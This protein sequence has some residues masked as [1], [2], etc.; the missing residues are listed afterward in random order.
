[1]KFRPVYFYFMVFFILFQC[2]SVRYKFK[3]RWLKRASWLFYENTIHV[4]KQLI[5]SRINWVFVIFKIIKV[6]VLTST[7]IILNITKNSSNNYMFIKYSPCMMVT[8][9]RTVDLNTRELKQTTFLTIRTLTG[10]KLHVFNQSQFCF[11]NFMTP[12]LSKTSLA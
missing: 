12:L 9:K 3:N 5:N 8:E 4:I 11:F 2:S 1:M 10:N 6:S 7:C